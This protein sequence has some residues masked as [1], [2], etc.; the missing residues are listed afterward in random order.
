MNNNDATRYAE[1]LFRDEITADF[2]AGKLGIESG[3]LVE[4]HAPCPHP[5]AGPAYG[6]PP[7]CS[8]TPIADLWRIESPGD[9]AELLA[10]VEAL[11][12]ERREILD[13]AFA[14]SIPLGM[15]D[16]QFNAQ[17][18]LRVRAVLTRERPA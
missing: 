8:A 7:S 6:C 15:T 9:R 11:E 12:G 5:C 4:W 18:I 10:R 3:W 14:A 16:G 17:I 13:L 1:R 2:K